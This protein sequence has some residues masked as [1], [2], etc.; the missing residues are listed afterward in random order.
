[1]AARMPSPV[2]DAAPVVHSVVIGCALV[3]SPHLLVLLESAAAEDHAAAR[4]DELR[5][6]RSGSRSVARIDA[7]TTPSSTK[8]SRQR[9]VELHRHA[10]LEQPLAQRRSARGPC[11]TDLAGRLAPTWCVTPTSRLRSTSAGVALDHVQ[12]DVVLLRH[13]DIQRRLGVRRVQVGQLVAED[14][15][16]RTASARRAAR[17]RGR[18]APPGSSRRSPGTQRICTGV[19]SST[20]DSTRGRG[21]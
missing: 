1:M 6:S 3:F 18:R 19:C 9:G 21:R 12:P 7:A 11:R 17:R 5:Y 20:K 8:R 4:P 14:A 15:W 2:L 10:G 13:D 16:R